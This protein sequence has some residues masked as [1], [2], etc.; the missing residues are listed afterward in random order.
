MPWTRPHPGAEIANR[1]ADRN[2]RAVGLAG[3]VHDAAHT[4]RDQV[5]AAAPGVG[6]VVAE[7][8]KLGVDQ[9]RVD[10]AQGIKAE[11]GARHH[12]RTIVLDQD[13]HAVSPF[14]VSSLGSPRLN[15]I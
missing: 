7:T 13:V 5:K 6:P 8:G 11:A 15:A 9:P 12:G 4:L 1:Q 10:L 14:S 2:R 3:D